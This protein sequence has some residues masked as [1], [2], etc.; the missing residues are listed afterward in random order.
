M[1][2]VFDMMHL[3]RLL[4]VLF[5]FIVL[6]SCKNDSGDDSVNLEGHLPAQLV[7]HASNDTTANSSIPSLGRLVF[8]DTMHDF[9]RMVEGETVEYSFD[10]I[11]NGRKDIIISE[12]K[13]SCGCTVAVWPEQPIK[14]GERNTIKVSFN[15]QGKRGMNEKAVVV[16]TNG[17]PSVYTLY[18]RSEV[19][20]PE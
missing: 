18:V 10:F 3:N 12:A 14:H 16:R 13:A 2:I 15:S 8:T 19:T 4:P 9:G 17:A 20:A 7:E 1:F 11:N 6:D 5:T